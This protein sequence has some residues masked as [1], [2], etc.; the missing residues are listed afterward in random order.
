MS[1]E[2]INSLIKVKYTGTVITQ[3]LAWCEECVLLRSREQ[4]SLQ[5]DVCLLLLLLWIPVPEYLCKHL[6][7]HFHLHVNTD[8]AGHPLHESKSFPV[9]PITLFVSYFYSRIFFHLL[10]SQPYHE[11]QA[12]MQPVTEQVSFTCNTDCMWTACQLCFSL[13]K[14]LRVTQGCVSARCFQMVVLQDIAWL[15]NINNK[16]LWNQWSN[17]CWPWR[18]LSGSWRGKVQTRCCTTASLDCL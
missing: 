1:T 7:D 6:N 15:S 5:R 14:G 8:A 10:I 3:K 13:F 2:T 16:L 4:T 11:H 18:P 9:S 17:L 12:P